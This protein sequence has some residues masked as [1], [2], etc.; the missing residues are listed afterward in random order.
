VYYYKI[1]CEQDERN[2]IIN[3]NL[4]IKKFIL[5]IIINVI[6][7]FFYKLKQKYYCKIYCINDID[8]I[9]IFIKM[10]IYIYSL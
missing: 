6:K 7:L 8:F 2:I 5:I 10:S 1:Y 4:N 9:L 3:D